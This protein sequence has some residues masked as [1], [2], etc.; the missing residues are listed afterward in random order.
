MSVTEYTAIRA[1][2]NQLDKFVMQAVQDGWQPVG[3]I[4]TEYGRATQTMVKES[5]PNGTTT[6]YKVVR[7]PINQ[8]DKFVNLAINNGW[9][10]VGTVARFAS[11]AFQAM[12]KGT[13]TSGEVGPKGDKGDKGEPGANGIDGAKG[14]K[15]DAGAI[16][17][18]GDKGE[19]GATPSLAVTA[20]EPSGLASAANLQS[21]AKALSARIKAI[22]DR[23]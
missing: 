9:Q 13:G 21:L 23:P 20:D 7:A 4:W 1:N 19:I 5:A 6:D 10:P 11:E 12:K 8:L 22:E 14:A 18:K 2:I 3:S 16:G 15:G 17:P